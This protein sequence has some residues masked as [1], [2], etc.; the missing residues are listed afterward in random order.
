MA[1]R[2]SVQVSAVAVAAVAT[3][4]ACMYFLWRPAETSDW[5]WIRW[6]LIVVVGYIGLYHLAGL[7]GAAIGWALRPRYAEDAPASK[8]PPD[9]G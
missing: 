9:R 6:L 8:E 4:L 2:G 7:L 3:V 1:R 5:V